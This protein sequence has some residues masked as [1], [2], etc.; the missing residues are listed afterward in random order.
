M[1]GVIHLSVF[2]V[3]AL[4]VNGMSR[5][6]CQNPLMVVGPIIGVTQIAIIEV[7]HLSNRYIP[8]LPQCSL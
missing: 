8:T 6:T 5:D 3:L 7:I 4:N 1:I 2:T